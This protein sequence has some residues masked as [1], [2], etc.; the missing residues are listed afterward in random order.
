M[1][2]PVAL[3]TTKRKFHKLLDN[4]TATRSQTSLA[5]NASTNAITAPVSSAE[6]P[7]KRSRLSDLSMDR[8]LSAASGKP[9]PLTRDSTLPPSLEVPSSVRL[10]GKATAERPSTP[11]IPRK[12]PNYTPY[13]HEQFL[14]RLKT[15]ADV[16]IWSSKPDRIGEVEWAKRGWICEGWNTVAC[17][18]GCEQRV[19]VLLRPKR[20]DKDGNEIENS[21]DISLEVEDELVDRYEDIIV[22]G[23]DEMCL[24]RK[25]GCKKDIYHI[26]IAQRI[27]CEQSL[28]LRYQSLKNI[29]SHLPPPESI[30]YPGAPISVL[31]KLLPT[32]FFGSDPTPLPNLTAI[33]LASFGWSGFHL[34]GVHLAICNHC[35]QRIGLWMYTATR[36]QEMSAKL[37]IP[38]SQ[39]RL[40]LLEAHR[41]HCPWKNGASQ[42]NPVDGQLANKPAWETVQYILGAFKTTEQH[43]DD[44]ARNSEEGLD[45]RGRT[46]KTDR[47]AETWS[48]L[49]L[50]LK[51]TTSKRS[52]K[53]KDL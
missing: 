16:K 27:R 41:E 14:G 24:W 37:N 40:N 39:L 13:S 47:L 12:T 53:E 23:H 49:K 25:A 48:K 29:E 6:P 10:V 17:K 4:L 21:E 45:S 36:L 31:S 44:S 1:S 42:H 26:P 51:K 8:P 3:N 38:E 32:T 35:F 2:A 18:G 33:A 46:E 11:S 7:P 28:K 34:D 5:K 9:R 30:T 50:R 19:V 15:F 22:T 43:K 20:K 52:L